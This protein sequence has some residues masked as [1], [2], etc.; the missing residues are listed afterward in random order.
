MTFKHLSE[1]FRNPVRLA[2]LSLACVALVAAGCQHDEDDTYA[3]GD[4]T[5]TPMAGEMPVDEAL[6]TATLRDAGVPADVRP[7]ISNDLGNA[8]IASADMQ[9][10]EIGRVYRVTYYESDGRPAERW[11][12]ANGLRIEPPQPREAATIDPMTAGDRQLDDAAGQTNPPS[13]RPTGG[14]LPPTTRPTG[15]GGGDGTG[16]Q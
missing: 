14:E 11:Y 12:N 2:A 4:G 9:T 10:T 16:P 6:R 1:S 15:M 3:S 8:Q 5:R 13:T 7:V